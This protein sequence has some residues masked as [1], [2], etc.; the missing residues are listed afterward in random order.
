MTIEQIRYALSEIE[1]S[2]SIAMEN[3]AESLALAILAKRDQ[4][5]NELVQRIQAEDP[6]ATEADIRYFEHND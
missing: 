2:F 6:Y 1:Q 5:W 3:G 4:L